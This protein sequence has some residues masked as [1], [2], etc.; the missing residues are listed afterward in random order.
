MLDYNLNQRA[1]PHSSCWLT[2]TLPKK[3]MPPGMKRKVKRSEFESKL[4]R[5]RSI[6][7][8]FLQNW[9]KGKACK[10]NFLTLWL[11]S[12]RIN[13]K[14]GS[15]CNS[16]AAQWILHVEHH[17]ACC[18]KRMHLERKS[19]EWP[20]VENL[21]KY[22]H[23]RS[24]WFYEKS[25]HWPTADLI[26]LDESLDLSFYVLDPYQY[27]LLFRKRRTY[28]ESVYSRIHRVAS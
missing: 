28:T 17:D 1:P 24:L 5:S 21:G 20:R 26:H 15:F 6:S 2:E 4:L 27:D 7:K 9:Q 8:G 16:V 3:E 11:N 23:Q 14:L 19:S 22:H 10:R 12:I 25:G 13:E 18:V